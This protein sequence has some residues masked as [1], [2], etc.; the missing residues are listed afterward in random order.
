MNQ[1]DI[2]ALE[3]SKKH[4][5]ENEELLAQNKPM[6]VGALHCACCQ[7]AMKR[8]HDN[9]LDDAG[10]MDAIVNGDSI[11]C[12]FCPVGRYTQQDS[13]FGTPYESVT[14][15]LAEPAEIIEWIQDL[16]DGK[17]PEIRQLYGE[18]YE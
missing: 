18:E 16:I 11:D 5:L 7:L 1:E 6:Q 3:A 17:N 4:W 12:S 10:V 15:G 2:E 13:C 9:T 8:Q 14:D